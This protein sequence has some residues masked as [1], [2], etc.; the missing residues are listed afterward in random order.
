MYATYPIESR[1]WHEQCKEWPSI[2]AHRERG[3]EATQNIGGSTGTVASQKPG[4]FA[5]LLMNNGWSCLWRGH[6]VQP[7]DHLMPLGSRRRR[8]LGSR[9]G[10]TAPPPPPTPLCFVRVSQL[11]RGAQGARRLLGLWTVPPEHG[12][13]KGPPGG[14]LHERRMGMM[15]GKWSAGPRLE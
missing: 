13:G 10:L 7:T 1:P 6:P 4:Q 3:R 14:A 9:T 11:E 15:G 2:S 12:Q 8:V 5:D